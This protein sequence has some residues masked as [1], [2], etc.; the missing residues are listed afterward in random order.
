MANE[1]KTSK[2]VLIG[3]E[4]I[5][6]PVRAADPVSGNVA[7]QM[8]Y[9]SV[10]NVV[11]VYDGTSWEDISAGSVQFIDSVSD[12][13]SIDLTVSS[14]QL[15]AD[16]R[17]GLGT[18]GGSTRV[19]NTI[20]LDG[21][22]SSMPYA[23]T[24]TDGS[25]SSTDWNTF[26]DKQPQGNYLTAEGSVPLT[27]NFPAGGQRL[28]DL[29]TPVA[30]QDATTKEYVDDAIVSFG[31]G[32][33]D[34]QTLS[35]VAANS[36]SLGAFT[37]AIIPDTSTIKQALQALETEAEDIAGDVSTVMQDTA[38]LIVLTGVAANQTDLGSF[39]GDIIPDASDIKEALQSLETAI[40][41][42]PDPIT[43]EG[44]WSAA[45]N[46]PAL[47]DG[48]GNIGDLYQVTAAGSVDFGSGAISFLVGDKVVYNG[49][50]WEKW[51]MTDGVTSVN[52][53]N[54]VVVLDSDDISEGSSNLY[55]TAARA[56]T[57]TVAN[58]I[59]DGV[60]DVAPSQN[61]VFDALALKADASAIADV[62]EGPASATDNAIAVYDGVTGKLIKN[63]VVTIDGAGQVDGVD[64]LD[65]TTTATIAG[66]QISGGAITAPGSLTITAQSGVTNVVSD[67]TVVLE[68]PVVSVQSPVF[69][70]YNS[71][72]NNVVTERYFHALS[73]AANVS[74]FTTISGLSFS[75]TTYDGL[76]LDF[77]IKEA[78]TGLVRIGKMYVAAD[79]TNVSFSPQYTET[80]I[81]GAIADGE[82]LKLQAVLSGGN[83]LI[84]FK[85]TK[86]SNACTMNVDIKL[87]KA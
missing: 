85:D 45:T 1:L 25:L 34:L 48:V 50:V 18:P 27:A 11:R 7:G 61:A 51:D 38:D 17:L 76:L 65:V 75:N 62:V 21:L 4:P 29:G 42:L 14:A 82:G 43:Y 69:E 71:G 53:Q 64:T 72:I 87:F 13:Q 28:T 44:T 58:A 86:A 49:T 36:T 84:Q 77:K 10:S 5:G 79:G 33:A 12:S 23:T 2:L 56:K 66:T 30:D 81:V 74:T 59:V 32:I 35:G 68:A 19:V 54:G 9:N 55:F 70:R 22:T 6:M 52:G 80:G 41:S 8:Y 83:I 16:L 67:N 40:E 46:T 15:E 3:G 39:T 63:S 73:L 26:N 31:P 60:T 37:G 24:T 78:T 20:E 57:A 47:A